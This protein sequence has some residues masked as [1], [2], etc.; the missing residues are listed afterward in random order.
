MSDIR[1]WGKIFRAAA[2]IIERETEESHARDSATELAARILDAVA[3]AASKK[4]KAG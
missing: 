4:S 1:I 3:T 2:E